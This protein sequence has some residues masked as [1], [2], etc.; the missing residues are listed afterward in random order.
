MERVGADAFDAGRLKRPGTWI[1]GF[2][3]D[4]CPFC[5]SFLPHL[6]SLRSPEGLGVLLADV[7]DEESPLWEAFGIDV[8]PTVVVFRD[9]APVYRRD[10]RLG[11]GLGPEDLRAIRA[12]LTQG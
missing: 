3:A 7:T 8:V 12:S 2:L 4:W 9:G 10:G 11:R 5:R 1:V 6:D